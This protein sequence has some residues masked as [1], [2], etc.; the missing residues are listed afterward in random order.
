MEQLKD[1][2]ENGIQNPLV[3]KIDRGTIIST[4]DCNG[5]LLHAM[6]LKLPWI[7]VIL[8][9]SERCFDELEDY[10]LRTGDWKLAESF[11]KPYFKFNMKTNIE[12]K[13]DRIGSYLKKHELNPYTSLQTIILNISNVCNY[14]CTFCPHGH[15]YLT[16]SGYSPFMLMRVI[17]ELIRQTDG[18]FFG[19][20]SLSG[21]GE[22][23]LH[24]EIKTILDKLN[25][26]T[27][28]TVLT[29]NG[30]KYEEMRDIH[31]DQIDISIY[32]KKEDRFYSNLEVESKLPKNV[33]LKRQYLKNNTFFNNRAGSAGP[34]KDIPNTCCYI[35]FMKLT[36]DVNGD[37]LQCCSDWTRSHVLGNLFK[38]NIWDIWIDG[39]RRDRELLLS[40]KRRNTV[41]CSR[42]NSP[43]NLYGKEFKDFWEGYYAEHQPR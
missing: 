31:A 29:T 2:A 24:P 7:P 21:F 13:K 28:S 6:W 32:G 16:P 9:V 39:L 11:C 15:G 14:F 8:Y 40:G 36:I 4:K 43:G 38:D 18:K 1:I 20:F 42:C 23:M 12:M 35:T 34:I 33:T 3:M 30:S 26:T 19:N 5:R 41:L 37:I 25:Q 27:G 10:Q 17:D 22:P